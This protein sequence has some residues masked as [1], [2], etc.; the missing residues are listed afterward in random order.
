MHPVLKIGNE[1]KSHIKINM[2]KHKCT[3]VCTK[4]N[5]RQSVQQIQ[6]IIFNDFSAVAY[7]QP[8]L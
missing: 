7:Y 3:A 5:T 4:N 6:E 2:H 1:A 8:T